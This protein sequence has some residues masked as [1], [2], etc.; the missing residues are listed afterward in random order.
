MKELNSYNSNVTKI[1]QFV[2]MY[3]L[4]HKSVTS[5]ACAVMGHMIINMCVGHMNY[6]SDESGKL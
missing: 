1:T 5:K 2:H 6:V 3:V 4:W